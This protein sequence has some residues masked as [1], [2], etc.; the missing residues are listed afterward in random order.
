LKESWRAN[1]ILWGRLD[2]AEQL[3]RTVLKKHPM[4]QTEKDQIQEQHTQDLQQE[5]LREELAEV[6]ITGP[7]GVEKYL[8]ED[9]RIGKEGLEDINTTEKVMLAIQAT[10][11][12]KN[13]F[14]HLRHQTKQ[15]PIM[16]SLA[17]FGYFRFWKILV[18][19]K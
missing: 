5:I 4:D 19:V 12:F 9:H 11:V 3:V 14:G 17:K 10:N 7:T 1:D 2:T 13:M 6:N 18:T 15:D 16:R 8:R